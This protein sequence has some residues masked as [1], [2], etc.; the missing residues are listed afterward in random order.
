MHLNNIINN[1]QS[2]FIF[3][4]KL[5]MDSQFVSERYLRITFEDKTR[6]FLEVQKKLYFMKKEK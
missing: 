1:S 6:I 3:H 4:M 2:L 5:K